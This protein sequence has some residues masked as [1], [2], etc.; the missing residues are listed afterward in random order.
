VRI[1]TQGHASHGFDSDTSP[2]EGCCPATLS[3]LP[4][5]AFFTGQDRDTESNLDHFLFRQY[6]STQGRW[7]T[8][9]PGGL[10]VADSTNPQTWNR[11]AYVGNNPTSRIDPLGL[12][13]VDCSWNDCG[14]TCMSCGGGG[15]GGGT[16]DGAPQTTYNTMNVGNGMGMGAMSACPGPCSGTAWINGQWQFVQFQAGASGASGYM[17]TSN[18][19]QGMHEANGTFYSDSQWQN[20]LAQSYADQILAQFNRIMGNLSA[21]FGTLASADPNDETI[22]G[23][24]ANFAFTCGDPSQCG[25]GRYDYGIHIECAGGGYDCS[26]G[27]LVV[28]DDTVSPWIGT[29]SFSDIF[30]G[31]FWEHGFVDLF[32]G[33]SAVYVFAQ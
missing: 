16:V 28:H 18:W 22:D 11:Y 14:G 24:H 7:T 9:D 32:G 15:G 13:I 27:P 25:P 4:G 30:S 3:G 31:S 26:G 17:L 20:Y 29:F 2:L 10:A 23:G 19:M 8:P 21:L 33:N 12:Y 1:K 5:P 6:N